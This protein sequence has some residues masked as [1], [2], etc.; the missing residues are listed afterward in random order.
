MPVQGKRL[1]SWSIVLFDCVGL[2]REGL[3]QSHTAYLKSGWFFAAKRSGSRA[4]ILAKLPFYCED[5]SGFARCL[6]PRT[7]ECYKMVESGVQSNMIYSR[8]SDSWEELTI[9]GKEHILAMAKWFL[10]GMLGMNPYLGIEVEVVLAKMTRML[11]KQRKIHG[12]MTLWEQ[13]E[14]QQQRQGSTLQKTFHH[15]AVTWPNNV[16]ALSHKI[17]FTQRFLSFLI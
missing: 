2:R 4:L 7:Q 15:W 3:A 8:K 14:K 10:V 16:A 1:K 11:G 9:D 5:V 17:E 12:K 6:D 13:Q